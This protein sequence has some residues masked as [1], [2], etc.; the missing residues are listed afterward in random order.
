M[1]QFSLK[2]TSD[3]SDWA[4]VYSRQSPYRARTFKRFC[5]R[6]G[7]QYRQ[8]NSADGTVSSIPIFV[9]EPA[10]AQV[11]MRRKGR[12]ITARC[13]ANNLHVRRIRLIISA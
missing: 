1:T 9:I 6:T 4:S 5:C 10:S 2:L 3:P 11:A 7:H 12:P 8:T 13:A